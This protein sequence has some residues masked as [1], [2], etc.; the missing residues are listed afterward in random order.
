MAR[1]CRWPPAQPSFCRDAHR[2]ASDA[3]IGSNSL[4]MRGLSFSTPASAAQAAGTAPGAIAARCVFSATQFKAVLNLER[5][6]KVPPH[7]RPL[8]LNRQRNVFGVAVDSDAACESCQ[9]GAE[10]RVLHDADPL[11]IDET[12][13][14]LLGPDRGKQELL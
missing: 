4:P 9:R 12:C 8:P 13:F 3:T 7:Q 1:S 10:Q 14:H 2:S 5:R 6:E 11:A